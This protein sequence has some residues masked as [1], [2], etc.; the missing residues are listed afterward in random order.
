MEWESAHTIS[1]VEQIKMVMLQLR[2][3]SELGSIL[4][5]TLETVQLISGLEGQILSSK[6]NID[7]IERYWVKTAHANLQ[8][9]DSELIIPNLWN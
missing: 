8:I 5:V 1:T 6:R 9:I 7:Y 4:R 2:N 3:D